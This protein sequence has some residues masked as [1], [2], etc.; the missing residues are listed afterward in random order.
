MVR[1]TREVLELWRAYK[2]SHSTGARNALIECYLPLAEFLAD[3]IWAQLPRC[4]GRGDVRSAAYIGLM[5]AVEGFEPRRGIQFETYA[6]VRIRGAVLDELRSADWAPRLVRSQ[7]QKF[8]AAVRQLSGRLGRKPTQSEIAEEFGL[9]SEQV[10]RLL[11]DGR[12][13]HIFSLSRP[14]AGR[15]DNDVPEGERILSEP[16]K[17][18]IT[19]GNAAQALSVLSGTRRRIMELY[20]LHGCTMREIGRAVRLSESRVCQIHGE[21]IEHLRAKLSAESYAME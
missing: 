19:H 16:L 21:I 14:S 10:W 20:Y 9:T 15:N 6:S 4:V 1:A 17:E 3:R 2:E 12:K 11:E 18:V 13:L 7:A 5:E 8:A